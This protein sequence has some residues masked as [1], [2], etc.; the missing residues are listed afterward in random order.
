[1]PTRKLGEDEKQTITATATQQALAQYPGS[2]VKVVVSTQTDANGAPVIK[3]LH[4][5]QSE[6]FTSAAD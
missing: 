5:G 1:M 2:M 4:A 3:I 6:G